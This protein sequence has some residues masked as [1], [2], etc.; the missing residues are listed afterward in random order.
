MREIEY[1]K[2][3]D[4]SHAAFTLIELLVVIAIIAIL[5]ALLLPALSRAKIKAQQ[6][7]CMNNLRQL[8]LCGI[9]YLGDNN[10]VFAANVPTF[11]ASSNSWIQGNMNVSVASQYGAVTPGV[12]DATNPLCNST[13]SFWQYDK[14]QGIYHCPGDPSV[15]GGVP[16][17]RSYSMNSWIGTTRPLQ[18]LGAS[19]AEYCMYLKETTLRSPATTWYVIDEHELSINDGLFLVC[20]PGLTVTAP[21]DLMATRHNRVYVLSFC[22]GH[23]EGV[24]LHDPRTNWPDSPAMLQPLNPDYEALQAVTTVLR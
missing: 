20:M 3:V 24:K 6:T 13:G 5:A 10:G 2:R 8:G 23:S 11:P 1:S 14:S 22:D 12:L 21:I 16:R 18:D 9:M 15:V 17:V 19:A 4:R 7:Q